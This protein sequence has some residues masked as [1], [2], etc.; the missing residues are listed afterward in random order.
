MT[1][2]AKNVYQFCS[3]EASAS[4]DH[5]FHNFVF[6]FRS[7]V[8]DNDCIVVALWMSGKTHLPSRNE[9]VKVARV[10]LRLLFAVL[11]LPLDPRVRN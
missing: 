1:T 6:R 5:N 7:F 10:R 9:I 8:I 2:L 3:D 11:Q 4:D